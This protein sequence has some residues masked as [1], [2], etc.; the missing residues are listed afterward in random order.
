MWCDVMCREWKRW[1]FSD[2]TWTA[3]WTTRRS[4]VSRLLPHLHLMLRRRRRL[5]FRRTCRRNRRRPLRISSGAAASVRCTG[6][7]AECAGSR[8]CS[9]RWRAFRRS[10]ACASRRR[11]R[12]TSRTKCSTWSPRTRTCANRC[13]SRRRAAR[14]Q[15]SSACGAATRARRISSSWRTSASCSPA[16]RSRATSL[17]CGAVDGAAHSSPLWIARLA[18]ILLCN[19]IVLNC[20]DSAAKRRRSTRKRSV[21]S[22]RSN[23]ASS[24]RSRS[25]SERYR[26]AHV[27]YLCYYSSLRGA[28]NVLFH[29]FVQKTRAY[30]RLVDDVPLDVKKRRH[31]QIQATFRQ[32]VLGVNRALV[33]SLQLI[34]V[35]GVCI[36]F[37]VNGVYTVDA[38]TSLS[39]DCILTA[40]VQDYYSRLEHIWHMLM[41][42]RFMYSVHYSECWQQ[43]H[44]SILLLLVFST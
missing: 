31:E 19:V 5:R 29:V 37:I 10:C 16:S 32:H 28:M 7:S 12:R 24:T 4:R 17:R 38:C 25:V 42:I 14:A 30:H 1:R 41:N 44:I 34:L 11:T 36:H 15:C 20:R 2:R 39:S 9:T 13:T 6:R 8:S 23:T 3:M 33:G 18:A 27:P 26:T 35:E 22:S 43:F 21:C 40:Y